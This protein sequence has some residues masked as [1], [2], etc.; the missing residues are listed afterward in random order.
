M[1]SLL[2]F[3]EADYTR[4]HI[5]SGFKCFGS[6]SQESDKESRVSQHP[7]IFYMKIIR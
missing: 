5:P 1:K 2:R 4:H 7:E 3:I 6:Y